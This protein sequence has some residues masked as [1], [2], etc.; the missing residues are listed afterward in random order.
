MNSFKKSFLF[1][2]IKILAFLFMLL[3]IKLD[4]WIGRCLGAIGY[5]LLSKKRKVVYA[6]LKTV[7]ASELFPSQL[8]AMT[9]DVF[10]NFVQT[11]V[12]LLC[13]PKIKRIG[14][15]KFVAV[16]GKENIDQALTLGKGV[17]FLAIHSGSWELA[18]VVGGVTKGR[19]HVVAND[20]SKMPQLDRML[21]EYR[22]IAGAHVI[23]AGVAT[24]EI[25]KSHA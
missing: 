13:L 20:Q 22:N 25:I 6:N 11:A 7:F 8:R 24:K 16:E 21:N 18:S 2:S 3:P 19:Y 17:I 12:E 4:L 15:E 10:I 23:I 5:H 9:R 14:L 1:V